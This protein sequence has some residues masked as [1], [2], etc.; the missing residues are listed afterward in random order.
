MNFTNAII[1]IAALSEAYKHT[2]SLS[3]KWE[4]LGDQLGISDLIIKVINDKDKSGCED[5][6]RELL[7]RWLQ[8]QGGEQQCTP[9]WKTLSEAV[10]HFDANIADTIVRDHQCNCEDCV[11]KMACM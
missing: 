3:P 11:G 10:R 2:Q 4:L 7:V 8:Q 9:S 6:L 5:K 1:I